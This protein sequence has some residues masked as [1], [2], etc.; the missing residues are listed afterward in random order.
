MPMPA[1]V[2]A[3]L[4]GFMIL[5]LALAGMV[6]LAPRASAAPVPD[7]SASPTAVARYGVSTVKLRLDGESSTQ[8]TPT[9]LVLVLDES[10]SIDNTEWGQLKDFA[11]SVVN[12][13]AA[14]GLF[15]NGG[16]VG[17]VGFAD[18]VTPPVSA[19]SG[20]KDAVLNAIDTN[21]KQN[22]GT[23][24]ACGLN[25][26]NNVMGP[27]D[28]GRN[29]LVIVITDGEATSGNTG[30][31]ATALQAKATVFAVGVGGGIQQATLEVIASGPGSDNTF[32]AGDFGSLDT[33][34]KQIVEAV[35]VPGATHPSIAV[36]LDAP[37]ELVPGTVTASLA[38]S[39]VGG[40]TA[41]GFTWSR[42]ELGDENLEIT[43]QVKH[44]G[45]PCGPLD[46]NKSVVYQDD[47]NASVTFPKVVVTVNCL[48][49]VAD[50]GPD[51]AVDEGSSV[52]LD[53]SGSHDPDGTVVSYA[54]SGADAGIG[55][56]TNAGAAV[57]TYN[58]LDDGA[59]AVTL[60]VTDD[61]GLTDGDSTTV[62]VNNV[63]PDLTLTS[64]PVDPHAVGTDV[65]FAGT[66]TDPGTLDTHTLSVA[67]GDGTTTEVPGVG[68]PVG[69]THQYAGAGIY[70]IAVTVTDDDGGTDTQHCGFVVVY[71]P[72]GGFVTGGGWINS[73]AGAYPADPSATGRANFGFVS[74]YKK[75]ATVPTGS[76]EFQFKAGN[77][78][79]HS[80]DY[81]WLV[82]AGNKAIYKGTGTVNGASG[83]SFMLSATDSTP[84][85]F[86]IRIWKT[87]DDTLVYDNQLGAAPDADPTTALA[88]G[89]I[90]IHK[91]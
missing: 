35:V 89:S 77:L 87:A 20:D 6:A 58:G 86:R 57:A 37:W 39:S 80:A 56:L 63:A 32:S 88:G 72:D 68:S 31:A 52:P 71:D 84:D 8:S 4:A 75:G 22:T 41:D 44:R 49:P 67:W 53:G 70:D 14:H 55:T 82:V 27:D 16:R 12:G 76:T 9:D 62:T 10:G 15:T 1:S 33:L 61:N 38:G 25:E 17:V 59:D 73:P 36:T 85:T 5:A 3:R 28:P 64:C 65:S 24:I 19:L 54:W 2:R 23:C 7:A 69:S 18:G 13:V 11:K 90:V 91:N 66:F 45:A 42:A 74:K 21:P 48:P 46:V 30:A 34:L 50:A 78:N 40:V 26:A 47:Q 79:F 81:Q 51:K 29:Q 60:T 83:Y 43:Y